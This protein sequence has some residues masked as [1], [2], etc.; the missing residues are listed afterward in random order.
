M[1]IGFVAD[2]V[3]RTDGDVV[4]LLPKLKIPPLPVWLAVHREIR[5]NHRI[6]EVYDFLAS[7]VPAAL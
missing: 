5:T 3:A 1:G 7:S 4:P 6:R 2:Y